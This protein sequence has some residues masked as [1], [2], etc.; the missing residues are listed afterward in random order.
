M[1]DVEGVLMRERFG[2]ERLGWAEVAL[3]L[4]L[5]TWSESIEPSQF[6][7]TRVYHCYHWDECSGAMHT[8]V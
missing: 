5:Y 8:M 7:L 2:F 3:T 6:T 4:T 1:C